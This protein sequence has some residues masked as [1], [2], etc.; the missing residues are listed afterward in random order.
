MKYKKMISQKTYYQLLNIFPNK[1]GLIDFISELN[2][3]ELQLLNKFF[4]IKND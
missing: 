3:K 2:S 1:K 4:K